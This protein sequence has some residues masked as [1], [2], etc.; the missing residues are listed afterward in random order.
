MPHVLLQDFNLVLLVQ[1]TTIYHLE[2]ELIKLLLLCTMPDLN[3]LSH[4]ADCNFFWRF[5]VDLYSH[6]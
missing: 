5:S 6:R 4:D 3:N 1:D 2:T